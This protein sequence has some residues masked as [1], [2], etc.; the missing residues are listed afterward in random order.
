ARLLSRQ[1]DLQTLPRLIGDHPWTVDI[2]RHRKRHFLADRTKGRALPLRVQ[3]EELKV[4][5]AAIVDQHL[6]RRGL[7]RGSEARFLR[8]GDDATGL[9][10]AIRP[11]D[12]IVGLAV[13]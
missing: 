5:P 2:G 12:D 6:D 4:T 9:V 7:C 11:E 8:T 3:L 1:H 13:L 10:A